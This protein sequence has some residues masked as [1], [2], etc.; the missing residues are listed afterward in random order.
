MYPD[1]KGE[2]TKA[3]QTCVVRWNAMPTLAAQAVFTS[4]APPCGVC[5]KE[6]EPGND[7]ARLSK[8]VDRDLINPTGMDEQVRNAYGTKRERLLKE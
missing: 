2:D 6:P 7:L 4:S 5:A 1:R 8:E 3:A